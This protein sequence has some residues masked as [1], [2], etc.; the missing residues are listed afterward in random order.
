MGASSLR[1]RLAG[2]TEPSSA[3][4]CRTARSI[5]LLKAAGF[6]HVDVHNLSAGVVALHN[7]EQSYEATVSELKGAVRQD[8]V[9]FTIC[10][11]GVFLEGLEV[12]FI[13]I[14]VGGT[15]KGL[16]VAVAGG[17]LAMIA[18]AITGGPQSAT[19]PDG[20]TRRMTSEP[21]T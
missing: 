15:S 9:A 12:V 8:W 2:C 14:A 3:R 7:E 17:L 20:K 18:V 10:F 1:A 16:P 13:V 6:G 11:K 4:P 21:I 19:G 5:G